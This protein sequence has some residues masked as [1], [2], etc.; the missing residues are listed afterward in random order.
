MGDGARQGADE[1]QRGQEGSAGVRHGHAG[2][3]KCLP[4]WK[5]RTL[6]FGAACVFILVCALAHAIATGRPVPDVMGQI[7]RLILSALMGM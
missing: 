1:L 3:R 7:F 2:R 5:R 4:A 6:K